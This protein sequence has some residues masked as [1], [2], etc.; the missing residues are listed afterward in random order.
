MSW[1]PPL[2]VPGGLDFAA[3]LNEVASRIAVVNE[4]M[5]S[6]T[7]PEIGGSGNGIDYNDDALALAAADGRERLLPEGVYRISDQVTLN[8]ANGLKLTGLGPGLSIIEVEPDNTRG[9]YVT[10]SARFGLENLT[11]RHQNE[12]DEF[13]INGAL[14]EIV[15]SDAPSVVGCEIYN[16]NS[17][18]IVFN[19]CVDQVADRNRCHDS[20]GDGIH[21]VYGTG[22]MTITN[23]RVWATKDD[24]ISINNYDAGVQPYG[25]QFGGVVSGNLVDNGVDNGRGIMLNGAEGVVVLGNITKA[26]AGPGIWVG[27][28]GVFGTKASRKITVANNLIIDAMQAQ[29]T[30]YACLEVGELDGSGFRTFNRVLEDII[31]AFNQVIGGKNGG[32]DIF[33]VVGLSVIGNNV[34]DTNTNSSVFST[35]IQIQEC[36]EVELIANRVKDTRGTPRI[37]N[38]AYLNGVD[39][40]TTALNRFTGCT[41]NAIGNTGCT[42]LQM[43]EADAF[44]W[45]GGVKLARSGSFLKSFESF[46]AAK[47]ML[48]DNNGTGAVLAFGSGADVSIAR[49]SAGVLSVNSAIHMN[50]ISQASAPAGTLFI[51]SADSLLKFRDPGGTLRTVTVT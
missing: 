30:G 40:V 51:D 34:R 2:F 28:S 16:S 46:I 48:V 3:N 50:G 23:N 49:T 8:G 18:C 27:L 31:V 47:G 37:Q 1:D 20:I 43:F 11:L 13:N 35:G 38:A 33:S 19:T 12:Q 15:D 26:A 5:P 25:D 41:A 7:A 45:G 6:F 10:D 4:A 32:I 24:G 42:N 14:V 22:R 39:N 17:Q 9:L 44:D 36:D 21:T 29:D